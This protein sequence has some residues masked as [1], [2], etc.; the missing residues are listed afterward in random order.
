VATELVWM[1]WGRDKSLSC[2]E[3]FATTWGFHS[4]RTSCC[5]NGHF[6]TFVTNVTFKW[7]LT[8]MKI[9]VFFYKLSFGN[10]LS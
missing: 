8:G 2:F 7:G 10:I 9:H 1:F 5:I 4:F 3:V 6:C